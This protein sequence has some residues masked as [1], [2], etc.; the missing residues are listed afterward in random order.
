[1]ASIRGWEV[2]RQQ[3]HVRGAQRQAWQE[4]QMKLRASTSAGRRRL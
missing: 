4:K 3:G 2:K 1:M